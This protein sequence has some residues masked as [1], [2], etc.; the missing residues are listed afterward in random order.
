[1]GPEIHGA[2]VLPDLDDRS[3]NVICPPKMEVLFN[4]GFINV[5]PSHIFEVADHYN[6]I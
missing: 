3:K 4:F 5:W 2:L 6:P 1:M